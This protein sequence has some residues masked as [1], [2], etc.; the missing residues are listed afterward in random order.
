MRY[1]FKNT[2]LLAMALAA[3]R[4][5]ATMGWVDAQALL[6]DAQAL[7]ATAVS[8]N[9]YDTKTTTNDIG[10]GEPMAIE[11]SVDVAADFTTGDET[12]TF[13]VV[14]SAATALTTP[15]TLAS[16][17]VLATTLV[18]GYKFWMPIPSGKILRYVGLNYTLAGTTPSVTV[19]ASIK[20]YSMI[21]ERK[22]YPDAV[23]IS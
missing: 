8:T 23:T 14:A 3:E 10:V 12:Y 6:S 5:K 17:A 11:I 20:P 9:A 13:A 16:R 7:T 4:L 2:A 1:N 15:T 21:E 19:T 18:A 22:Y